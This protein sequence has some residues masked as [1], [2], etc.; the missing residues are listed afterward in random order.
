MATTTTRLGVQVLT[1]RRVPTSMS[2][3]FSSTTT[4]LSDGIGKD[5]T[6]TVNKTHQPNVQTDASKQGMDNRKNSTGGTATEQKD[7]KNG[8]AK[9]KK[10]FPEAPD[11]IG[12]Q[13]ERGGKGH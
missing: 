10:E 8:A 2:R 5:K 3:P 12:F 13:D 7:A 1:C 11:A 6:H 4:L 9:A